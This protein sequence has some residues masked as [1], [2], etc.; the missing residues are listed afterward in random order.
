MTISDAD[1]AA[2]A[3]REVVQRRRVYARLVIT[4]RMSQDKADREIA[5]MEPIAA[6]YEARVEEQAKQERLL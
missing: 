2:C 6:D 5:L 4:G 3:R 1:K